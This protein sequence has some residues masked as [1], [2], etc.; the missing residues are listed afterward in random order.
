[1]PA[2][3]RPVVTGLDR[4]NQ[5]AGDHGQQGR[6]NAALHHANQNGS[7]TTELATLLPST[8]HGGTV[9]V[10]EPTSLVLLSAG[11]VGLWFLRLRRKS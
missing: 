2:H 11:L 1:M 6:D 7:L 4:A 5:V 9:S 3:A 8:N 10:P